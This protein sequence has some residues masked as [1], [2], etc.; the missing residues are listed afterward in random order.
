MRTGRKEEVAARDEMLGG[1]LLA[2]EKAVQFDF[3]K[4]RDKVDSIIDRWFTDL[5]LLI[6]GEELDASSFALHKDGQAFAMVL[7][8][9]MH[10]L[11]SRFSALNTLRSVGLDMA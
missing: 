8:G 3:P 1:N 9:Q 6:S 10:L 11:E 7:G 5:W 4:L 2:D